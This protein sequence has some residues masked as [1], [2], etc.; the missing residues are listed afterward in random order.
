MEI[1]FWVS[2][3][4]F[5]SL[6]RRLLLLPL[7]LLQKCGIFFCFVFIHNAHPLPNPI[8]AMISRSHVV[9]S[10]MSKCE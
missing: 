7:L 6:F 9:N 8:C 1:N 10:K 5:L 4:F 3:L 2:H